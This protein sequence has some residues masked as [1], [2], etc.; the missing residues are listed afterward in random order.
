MLYI[1]T[2][3]VDY[4][5]FFTF[6]IIVYVLFTLSVPMY[7]LSLELDILFLYKYIWCPFLNYLLYILAC[8]IR[9]KYVK[10]EFNIKNIMYII[11]I[12]VI[13][14]IIFYVFNIFLFAI[15][16][17][18][19]GDFI[20]KL[21]YLKLNFILYINPYS[22][23]SGPSGTIDMSSDNNTN[24]TTSNID[25]NDISSNSPSSSENK[26]LR[27]ID[28]INDNNVSS[29]KSRLSKQLTP[30]VDYSHV[31]M[32]RTF[33]YLDS[34]RRLQTMRELEKQYIEKY[35]QANRAFNKS[36]TM[37]NAANMNFFSMALDELRSNKKKLKVKY[38][39]PMDS[40]SEGDDEEGE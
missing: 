32:N 4:E 35:E 30:P 29:N 18:F 7:F 1:L 17:C 2:F 22:N 33:E 25:S 34:G 20:V 26:S 39:I 16:F 21:L 8:N 40:D 15:L 24:N 3:K 27:D 10:V 12:I 31:G 23:D 13:F 9:G 6:G 19:F 36:P 37:E 38:N 14:K 5:S 11:T 28:N